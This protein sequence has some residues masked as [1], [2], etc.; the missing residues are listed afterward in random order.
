MNVDEV[1]NF[2]F[3]TDRITYDTRDV[4]LYALGL[5]LG[6]TDLGYVYERD[7]TVLP[8]F[9]MVVGHPGS[10]MAT[11]ALE[12]D[13]VQLLHAEQS[14]EVYA[15]LPPDGV[16]QPRY[17]V[18]GIADKGA[19]KG[20]L[21]YI[22]KL[23]SDVATGDP[24]ARVVSGLFCRADGG[25]GDHGAVPA[26]PAP[27]PERA[28]DRSVRRVVDERAALIYRLSGD[29]NP[30]HADPQVAAAAGYDAPIL[31]GLCTMGMAGHALLDHPPLLASR[32]PVLPDPG[33][34]AG[35]GRQ[36]LGWPPLPMALAGRAAKNAFPADPLA[37][38]RRQPCPRPPPVG[39]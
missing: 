37:A 36:G 11:P 39:R 24:V 20:A 15:P 16:M 9:A 8:P 29:M 18:L 32:H 23:L 22:E 1:L 17:R 7:L 28:P 35:P 27:L 2:A 34:L 21:V 31:H 33:A 19:E 5:G 25:C 14:L 12:V 30:L 13:Y 10:W 4:L 6:R 26:P 38:G 3:P